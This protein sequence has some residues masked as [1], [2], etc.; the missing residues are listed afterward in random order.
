VK[1][2]IPAAARRFAMANSTHAPGASG[3]A[4]LDAERFDVYQIALEFLGLVGRLAPRRG[5]GEL[6]DQLERASSSIILNTAEG[7]GRSSSPEKA[8]F[9]VIARGS[10]TECAAIVDV[11]RVRALAAPALCEHARSLLVRITQM[12][13]KLISR[14]RG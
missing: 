9:F 6:R 7:L 3:N 10:T 8:R 11:L 4:R 5:F 13:S 12:L 2:A 1:A 14:H